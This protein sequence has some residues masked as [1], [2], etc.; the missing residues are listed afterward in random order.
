MSEKNAEK[1]GIEDLLRKARLSEPPPD[2]KQRITAVARKAW[3]QAPLELSWTIPFR[4]LAV[5]A[6]AAV[7]IIWL[8]N[9][10][11]DYMLARWSSGAMRLANQQ[12][13]NVETLPEMPYS[14]FARRLAGLDR[15]SFVL[16]A[17][18]LNKHIELL[19]RALAE[20]LQSDVAKPPAPAGGRS[21][22]ILNPP[23]AKSCVQNV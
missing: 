9:Y 19:R 18:A 12:P 21:R 20:L 7:F 11:S 6:A 15:R 2:V 5:S 14:L 13:T 23:R 3:N 22:V 10:G 1:R 8:A 4:R 17:S 16:D